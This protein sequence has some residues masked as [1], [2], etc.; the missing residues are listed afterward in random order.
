MAAE[1]LRRGVPRARGRPGTRIFLPPHPSGGGG[2][3]ALVPQL[4]PPCPKALW[5]RLLRV[6]LAVEFYHQRVP[7]SAGPRR[8]GAHPHPV[9]LSSPSIVPVLRIG[10]RRYSSCAK[11]LMM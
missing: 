5:R 2:A 9:A 4:Q 6:Y 3:L 10:R 7:P 1:T 11:L 8:H